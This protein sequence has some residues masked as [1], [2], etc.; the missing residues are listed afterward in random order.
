MWYFG[1]LVVATPAPR[2]IL[3]SDFFCAF[4]ASLCIPPQVLPR[5]SKNPIFKDSGPKKHSLDDFWNW[6]LKSWV[7]G[8]FGLV[9]TL[10]SCLRQAVD[11]V[12]SGAPS[13]R[14]PGCRSP[15][16]DSWKRPGDWSKLSVHHGICLKHMSHLGCLLAGCWD[17][18]CLGVK[19]LH[20]TESEVS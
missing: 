19:S 2:R 10:Q 3:L 17:L 4:N 8:P 15:S 20:N 6:V 5:K 14:P 13:L 11:A 9:L 18:N 7:L 16:A 1:A 12:L